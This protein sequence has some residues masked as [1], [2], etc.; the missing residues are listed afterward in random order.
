VS[1][2]RGA[3]AL[4]MLVG[5]ALAAGCSARP[6]PPAPAGQ[7][8]GFAPQSAAF[9]VP[10]GGEAT[11]DFRLT[12]AVDTGAVLSLASGGDPD[13]RIEVLSAEGGLNAGLRIH[14][15]GRKVGVR[16]GTL[17]IAT[18]LRAPQQVPLLF[19]LRVRGTL[20]IAPTNPIIDLNRPGAKATFI[21]IGSAQ[22]DFAVTAV[23]I[24]AGPF[25]ASF[26]RAAADGTFRVRVAA[27]T[28]QMA[29]GARGA[30]G[31]LVV[32]SNDAAEPR[33]EIPLFAWGSV[34]PAR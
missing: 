13:L 15:M 5:L 4:G 28:E 24:E 34:E 20:R 11:E 27:L 9:D 31:T 3:A 16:V 19:S 6:R 18:G 23:E 1:R 8:L 26:E 2:A 14:A 25:A 33:K 12:G 30:V 21:E 22:T 7:P 17:L 32:R 10:F 29:N